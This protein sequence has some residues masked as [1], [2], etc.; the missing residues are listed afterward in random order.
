MK[1]SVININR[2]SDTEF[3]LYPVGCPVV[4]IIL[5]ILVITA[6]EE[7]RKVSQNITVTCSVCIWNKK[8]R[9]ASTINGGER[10][11]QCWRFDHV[12]YNVT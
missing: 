11:K 10:N 7:A 3:F 4:H 2:S 9:N 6:I 5:S 12:P 1:I 8:L